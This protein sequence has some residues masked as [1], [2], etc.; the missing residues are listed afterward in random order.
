MPN[1][2]RRAPAV[3]RR[4]KIAIQALFEQTVYDLAAAATA[5]GISTYRLREELKKAHV[6]AARSIIRAKPAVV[7]GDPRSLTNTKGEVSLS[8]CSRR[9]ARISSP[10]NGC[11]LG[12]PFLIRRT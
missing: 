4:V 6:A 9:R 7:N 8:R 10:I 11:V 5:G 12:V 2:R 1:A 3:P